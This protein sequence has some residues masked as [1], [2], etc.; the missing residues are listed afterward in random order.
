MNISIFQN[1]NLV[2]CDM[3]LFWIC[4]AIIFTN[5]QYTADQNIENVVEPDAVCDDQ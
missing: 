2:H 5:S 4:L 3:M 1:F